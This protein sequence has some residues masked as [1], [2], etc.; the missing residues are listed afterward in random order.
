MEM[1]ALT[2]SGAKSRLMFQFGVVHRFLEQGVLTQILQLHEEND[3]RS[4]RE[5]E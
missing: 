4:N 3:G 1:K 5:D 2:D